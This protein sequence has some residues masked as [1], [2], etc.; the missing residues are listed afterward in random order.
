MICRWTQQQNILHTPTTNN[1]RKDPRTNQTLKGKLRRGSHWRGIRSR[2]VH[3]RRRLRWRGS[4]RRRRHF[5]LGF[6]CHL[7]LYVVLGVV[8]LSCLS[9][10]LHFFFFTL[11]RGPAC[12][13]EP[14][15]GDNTVM[16]GLFWITNQAHHQRYRR[17]QVDY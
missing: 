12:R 11:T 7:S 16:R 1:P 2:H 6:V 4:L 15:K 10:L 9:S 3:R 5:H 13:P 8:S 14:K 17:L